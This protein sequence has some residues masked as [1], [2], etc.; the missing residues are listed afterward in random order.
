MSQFTSTSPSLPTRASRMYCAPRPLPATGFILTKTFCPPSPATDVTL[1]LYVSPPALKVGHAAASFCR[2]VRS[3]LASAAV[4]VSPR[5]TS[6]SSLLESVAVT[7]A[8]CLK[9]LFDVAKP[10][11]SSTGSL[12]QGSRAGGL[13]GGPSV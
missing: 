12:L 5:S 4:P 7:C 8:L 13:Y 6:S 3:A 11:P 2:L 9:L 1:V 10:S